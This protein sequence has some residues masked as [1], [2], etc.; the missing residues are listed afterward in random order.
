MVQ[1]GV[2]A[3]DPKN[4]QVKSSGDAGKISRDVP[5]LFEQRDGGA[6]AEAYGSN[7][8]MRDMVTKAASALLNNGKGVPSVLDKDDGKIPLGLINLVESN[9]QT[10]AQEIYPEYVGDR[11]ALNA[12]LLRT[13]A[14]YVEEPSVKKNHETGVVT[15]YKTKYIATTNIDIAREWA[16]EEKL[17]PAHYK[18][19]ADIDD[20]I[21]PEKNSDWSDTA[22]N[23]ELPYLKLEMDREGNAKIVSP[24]TG[25]AVGSKLNIVPLYLYEVLVNYIYEK[26]KSSVVRVSYHRTSGEARV[27]DITFDEDRLAEVYGEDYAK[28]IIADSYSGSFEDETYLHRGFVKVPSIG[29]SKFDGVTRSLNFATIHNIELDVEPDLTYV[30]VEMNKVI[31]E[32]YYGANSL[33]SSGRIDEYRELSEALRSEKTIDYALPTDPDSLE[34]FLSKREILEGSTFKKKLAMFMMLTPQWFPKF[35]IREEQTS[36]KP[37]ARSLGLL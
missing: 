33:L 7:S 13:S 5:E 15:P 30:N 22:N 35:S 24:R 19:L 16:G 4:V 11:S 25:I 9:L 14:C 27:M 18:K 29:E 37:E 8:K 20:Y 31:G 10:L 6:I 1:H 26:A 28:E 3:F 2:S 23:T 34:G 17:R 32:F 12:Y 36:D 21:H